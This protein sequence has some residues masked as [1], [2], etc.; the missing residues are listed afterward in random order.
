VGEL[1]DRIGRTYTA[2]RR[3][4][5]RLRAALHAALGDARTVLN[6]GAGAGAYE[7]RDRDV[8]AV[9]P[10]PVMRA[11]RPPGS[12]PVIDARAEALPFGDGAFDAA[13][14]VFSDHHWTD[15]RAGLRE[16]RRVSRRRAVVFT[17]DESCVDALWLTRD[18]LPGFRR[19]PGMPF[20]QITEA[21]GATRVEVV[22]LAH[23]WQDGI[24]GAFWRRPEAYF[25]E[26]V[27]AGIS[28]FGRLP[29]QEVEDFLRALRRDL[30]SGEWAR[31]NADILDRQ[32]I[33]IGLRLVV[34]EYA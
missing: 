27:R 1:Y 3:E 13:M 2:T 19:L 24:L 31:R 17:W 32:E 4:D 34:A 12:P 22:P 18:Y 15:R 21:L 5:P 14:A 25:D 29:A 10:S 9:E 8:T 30:D 23:D 11:H 7:P 28:V 16:L 20:E 33:D 6:V 26:T